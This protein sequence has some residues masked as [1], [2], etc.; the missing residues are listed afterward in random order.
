MTPYWI[1]FEDGSKGC[2]EGQ[3]ALDAIKIA[4][5]V[6]GKKVA[7]PEGK[8]LHN[9]GVAEELAKSLPYPAN[10]IIWQFNHPAYGVMPSF[11]R[12]PEKCSGKNTCTRDRACND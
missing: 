10:P 11:C 6:S 12:A 8:F 1:I 3:N 2:C 5:K 4:E 9:T 7:L